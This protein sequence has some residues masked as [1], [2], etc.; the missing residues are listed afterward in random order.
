V[1]FVTP[2]ACVVEELPPSPDDRGDN[3]FGSSGR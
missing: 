2:A 3:G 1:P